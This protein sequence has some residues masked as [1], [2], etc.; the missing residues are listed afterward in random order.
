MAAAWA[1]SSTGV[2]GVRIS[3]KSRQRRGDGG[4]KGGTALRREGASGRPP[5]SVDSNGQVAGA[6][7]EGDDYPEEK[8]AGKKLRGSGSFGEPV[9][10]RASTA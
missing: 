7:A 6:E 10:P 4:E 8:V 2:L 3:L 5:A 1:K 9:N